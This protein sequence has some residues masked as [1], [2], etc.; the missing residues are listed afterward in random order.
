MDLSKAKESVV[1]EIL[2]LAELHLSSQLTVVS[3]A[4]QRAS[5]LAG[6]FGAMATALAATTLAAYAGKTVEGALLLAGAT[7]ASLT[8]TGCV[9]C[10]L[11]ASSTK[12]H[13]A[14][15]EPR[16]WW[17]DDVYDGPIIE[18]LVGETENYQMAIDFNVGVLSRN[19]IYIRWGIRIGTA[20]PLIASL[21]WATVHFGFVGTG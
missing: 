6:I 5:G 4:A 7:V 18:A 19:A 2:R 14:G 12:F 11:A 13:V 3:A 21:V 20:A 9:L 15:N 10:A 1:R 16:N 8:Y 17:P